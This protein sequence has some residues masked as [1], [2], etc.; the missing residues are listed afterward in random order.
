MVLVVLVPLCVSMEGLACKCKVRLAH[1]LVL[2]RVSV[3]EWCNVFRLGFPINGNLSFSSHF[4]NTGAECVHSD[5]GTFL[6]AH[7]L[8][9][10]RSSQDFTLGI[11]G[12]VVL[13]N[14]NVVSAIGFACFRLAETNA[15]N[16]WL[17][18]SYLRDARFIDC[19][20]V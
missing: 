5:D 11:S 19:D 20:R 6:D 4:T 18:V 12:Q 9:E 2:S 17:T 1:G 15:G 16:L 8:H 3:D 13:V 14:R 10:S 7:D